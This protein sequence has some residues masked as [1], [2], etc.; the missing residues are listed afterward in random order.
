VVANFNLSGGCVLAQDDYQRLFIKVLDTRRTQFLQ[1]ADG[2][3]HRTLRDKVDILPG[4][5]L[6]P[7]PDWQV[8]SLTYQY[9]W[10]DYTGKY[11]RGA[12]G[13]GSAARV[14]DA[15]SIARDGEIRKTVALP[16]VAH[17]ATAEAVANYYLSV[18]KDLPFVA[19][20]S[21]RGL[22]GL[23]DDVLDGV[24]ITHYNGR[25]TSGWE[26]HAVW[27]L[28]KTFDPK[29]MVCSFTALDVEALLS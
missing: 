14:T 1:N 18:F 16:Y 26:D 13:G 8:N 20:Y 24:P 17:D 23:E 9:G 29:R 10:N 7:K 21:R 28:S 12:G 11:E 15:T 19:H 5:H 2:D 22:C 4:F 3:T 25:G 27:I 6:E